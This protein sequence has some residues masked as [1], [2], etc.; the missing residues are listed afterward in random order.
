MVVS[1]E[2]E[3]LKYFQL[4]SVN[5][6]SNEKTEENCAILAEGII[7]EFNISEYVSVREAAK[8]KFIH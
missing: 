7:A 5:T 4:S 8:K 1:R 3:G 2:N 6:M